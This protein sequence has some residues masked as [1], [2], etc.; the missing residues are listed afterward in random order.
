MNVS[1]KN[2]ATEQ[3][4][5]LAGA[6]GDAFELR[7]GELPTGNARL[8]GLRRAGLQFFLQHG[9]PTPKVEQ[10]KFTNIAP[11]ARSTFDWPTTATCA[12][13]EARAM[14]GGGDVAARLV[15]VGGQMVL[16]LCEFNQLPEG[17]SIEP[18]EKT[19]A[20]MPGWT[21]SWFK[22]DFT[23]PADALIGLNT[24]FMRS[25]IVIRIPAGVTIERPIEILQLI[26]RDGM[27]SHPRV[28]V[29]LGDGAELT[30]VENTAGGAN[31]WLNAVTEIRMGA[32]SKLNFFRRQQSEPTAFITHHTTISQGAESE[33]LALSLVEGAA[34][35]RN[36]THVRVEGENAKTNV[37]GVSL[38][39]DKHHAD[40]TMLIEHIVPNTQAEA[41]HRH[42]VTAGGHS[43]FQGK[44]HVHP[45]AQKT[46][47]AMMNQNLM[48]SERGRID[49]KPELEIYADDVKCA[50]GA[51]CGSLDETALFYMTSRGIPKHEAQAMLVIGFLEDLLTHIQDTPT[52]VAFSRQIHGWMSTHNKG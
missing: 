43:V 27:Q 8:M 21:N 46:D 12:V 34:K 14:S 41:T 5:Q 3:A 19:L 18:L 35:L 1:V 29:E 7:Q 45:N 30:L 47:A 40:T 36:S 37:H 13:A 2:A 38:A 11:L 39:A 49:T 42:V 16:S 50:H 4:K 26:P 48:L 10:W 31:S 24:A 51:T 9:F 20:T 17:V 6:W 44:F 25:G 22:A 15:L 33:L 28:L 23:Q 32:K 52:Q